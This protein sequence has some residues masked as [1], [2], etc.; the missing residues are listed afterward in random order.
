MTEATQGRETGSSHAIDQLWRRFRSGGDQVTRH[1]L[2]LHYAP[3]VKYVAG[4]FGAGLRRAVDTEDLISFGTFGLIEAVDRFEPER[5]LRFETYA[6]NRIRGAILDELRRLDWVP[7]RVRAR[8]RQVQEGMAELEHRLQRTCTEEELADHLELDIET[9][10]DTLAEMASGGMV[11]IEEL[12][13]GGVP[14]AELLADPDAVDPGAAAESSELR[15]LLL[16]TVAGLPD[17]DRSV[18]VLY[19][20]ESMTLQQ[21]A[22]ILGVTESRVSQIHAKAV[23]SLRNRLMTATRD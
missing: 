3:L 2:I 10:R 19:Y 17:R 4:R 16:D 23:L 1:G 20:F 15:R 5:G 13:P 9:L 11:A 14:F 8:C 7:R 6:A 21:I 22:G 12:T 18:V